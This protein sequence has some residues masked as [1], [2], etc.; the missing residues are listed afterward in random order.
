MKKE[1]VLRQKSFEFAVR[2]VQTYVKLRKDFKE[3][4][5]SLQL[6]RSGTAI[7]ALVREAEHAESSRDFCHKLNI[8]LKEA[9]E[10]DYWIELFHATGFLNKQEF[11]SLQKD[12][13]ELLRILTAIIKTLKQKFA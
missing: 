12:I 6:V 9:N 8:A 2:V 10:C 4:S 1:G 11:E 13:N 5:L 3:Y 7:G